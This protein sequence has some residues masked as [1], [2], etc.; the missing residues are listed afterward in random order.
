MFIVMGI[1]VM[2]MMVMRIIYKNY[3][4]A[5]CYLTAIMRGVIPAIFCCSLG[6]LDCH[7]YSSSSGEHLHIAISIRQEAGDVS[8]RRMEKMI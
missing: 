7:R 2:M 4:I 6:A 5:G 8:P 3:N 1:M